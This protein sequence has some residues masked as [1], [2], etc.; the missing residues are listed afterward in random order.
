MNLIDLHC[1]T[2][3][4]LLDL[5]GEGDLLENDGSVSIRKLE[6][7]EALAQF[8]ACFAYRDAMEGNTS[9]EQYNAGYRRV[10]AMTDYLHEQAERWGGRLEIAAEPGDI[11]AIRRRGKT[12]AILTVEEGGI[13]NGSLE[14][15]EE[16]YRRDVRL[17]T[18]LWNYENCIG[19]PGS[20]EPSVMERGLTPFGVR[21][22]ERMNELGMIVDVSHASD[23]VF[24]DV[25]KCSKKPVAATHSNCRALA[26]HPRNLTDGM[27]R[28]LG[29]R[30]GVTG[31]N[32]YG[33]FLGTPEESR[34][35]EMTAHVLHMLRAGGEDL[36]AIGTDFDG[37]DGM[38]RM[39]IPDTGCMGR[40]WEAL[41]KE[42]LSESQL[43]KIWYKNALR[44][45]KER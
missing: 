40:L 17:I 42:G 38:K 14:R 41:K 13:L 9:A 31:L 39:D 22:V 26:A 15:L 8:F 32:L 10:L 4:R 12:A 29:E 21:V 36:P 44:I 7:E 19:A 30:G 43:D 23:G 5:G 28:A 11:E 45:W 27:L 25:M 6:E 3:W 20:R 16:L 33:P 37:F 34:L 18:L 2:L 1:D 24:W 35:E